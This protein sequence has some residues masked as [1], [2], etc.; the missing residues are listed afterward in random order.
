M[1]LQTVWGQL[2]IRFFQKH[3]SGYFAGSP[4]EPTFVYTQLNPLVL[5]GL[6]REVINGPETSGFPSSF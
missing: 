5:S 1:V 2:V 4:N 3:S 6:Q